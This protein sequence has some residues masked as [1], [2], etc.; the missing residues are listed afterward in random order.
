[1]SFAQLPVHF[2]PVAFLAVWL[3]SG[4]KR[5]AV[6]GAFDLRHA[7]RREL[8]TRVP[9]QNKKAP[10]AGLGALGRPAEFCFE[11]DLGSGLCHFPEG[12]RKKSDLTKVR[13]GRNQGEGCKPYIYESPLESIRLVRGESSRTRR[14]FTLAEIQRVSVAKP[15]QVWPLHRPAAWRLGTLAVRKLN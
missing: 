12:S 11:T 5:E 15:D 14:P 8:R 7:A 3:E 2:Q 4:L 1:M 6:E 10:G 13:S 9:W